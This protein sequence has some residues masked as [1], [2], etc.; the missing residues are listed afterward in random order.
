MINKRFLV[1]G[2]NSFSGA[3]CVNQ[4]LR[5]GFE[6]WGISRS[7]E[8]NKIFLPYKSLDKLTL[9]R[10]LF[11]SLNLK[12]DLN[13]ILNLID[14]N[15]I[16]HVINFAAQGMVAES[17]HN[18]LDWYQTNLISQIAFHDELRKRENIE[19]YVH[20]TT[21]EVYGDTKDTCIKENNH[22]EPS[23]P[24]AVSRAA[25]DLHLQSFFR[26]YDFPVVFTRAANVYGPG[27]QLYR[28]IPRT[29]LSCIS[30][31]KFYLHGGGS[32]K[33]AFIHIE[34]TIEATIKIAEEGKPGECFHISTNETI[35]IKDVVKRIC[36]SLNVNY[37]DIVVDTEERLGKDKSY[38]LDSNKLRNKFDWK[39]KYNFDQGISE[40]ISWILRNKN[41]VMNM[42]WNYEHKI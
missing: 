12:Y 2:S 41:L 39:E 18:P 34:D 28:V 9:K 35:S 17:W 11:K 40:T 10:F 42:S 6:V 22:F 24:Y 30:G 32:S 36:N 29:I 16:S 33:R 23:T 8:P 1:I 19:K 37:Y 26:A 3:H 15:K 5:K 7:D 21:P 4:L 38:F 25:C 20:V 31:E 13:D 14:K 27:Q